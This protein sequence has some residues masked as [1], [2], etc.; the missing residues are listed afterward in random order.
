M[1]KVQQKAKR[2]R[3]GHDVADAAGAVAAVVVAAV[4]VAAAVTQ[5]AVAI[6]HSRNTGRCSSR[7]CRNHRN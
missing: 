3:Q 1:E 4:A 6:T 7:C 5:A 2:R